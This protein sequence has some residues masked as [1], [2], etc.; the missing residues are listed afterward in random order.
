MD[1]PRSKLSTPRGESCPAYCYQVRPARGSRRL[2]GKFSPACTSPA[3]SSI[4]NRCTPALLQLER[5]PDGRYPERLASDAHVLAIAEYLR[6]SAITAARRAELYAIVTNSDGAPARR[7]ALLGEMG[8]GAVEQVID[9]GEDVVTQRLSGR[10]GKLSTQCKQ[11]VGRW[12]G[13][14]GGRR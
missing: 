3:S 11:A 5:N 6:R 13:R 7:A 8:P 10:T 12:Y 14:I 1:S 2:R 4:F 9:P